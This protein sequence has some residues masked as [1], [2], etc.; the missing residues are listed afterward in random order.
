MSSPEFVL[1]HLHSSHKHR[2]FNGDTLDMTMVVPSIDVDHMSSLGSMKKAG[3]TSNLSEKNLPPGKEKR[4]KVNKSTKNIYSQIRKTFR[5]VRRPPR[6]GLLWRCT[7]TSATSIWR[8]RATSLTV[9][10]S[11]SSGSGS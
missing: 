6:P 2:R 8:R 9:T 1:N 4:G 5:Q 11:S 7:A 3:S 10:L